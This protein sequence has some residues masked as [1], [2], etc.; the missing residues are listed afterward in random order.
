[1]LETIL[2]WYKQCFST[3]RALKYF[4]LLFWYKCSKYIVNL[5]ITLRIPFSF[6]WAKTALQWINV[7]SFDNFNTYLI[8]NEIIITYEV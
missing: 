1:M 4:D 6:H 5:I 2:S 7:Y 8:E 3:L